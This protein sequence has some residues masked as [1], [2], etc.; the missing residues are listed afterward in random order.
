MHAV[1]QW[2]FHI[3]S[4]KHLTENQLNGMQK[5]VNSSFQPRLTPTN[6]STVSNCKA[7]LS[8]TQ[9]CNKH[10]SEKGYKSDSN[11]GSSV[12]L[13]FDALTSDAWKNI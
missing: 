7:S 5:G 4:I 12:W 2:N 13:H 3:Q 9:S 11:E 6:T 10:T 1:V 8:V